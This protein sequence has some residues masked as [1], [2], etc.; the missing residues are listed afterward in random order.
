VFFSNN[1]TWDSGDTQLWESNGST[2]DYPVTVL[3][4]SG[5][6]TV[7]ATMNIPNVSTSGTYYIIAYVDP[8]TPSFPNGFFQESTRSNNIAVYPVTINTSQ[9]LPDLTN[10]ANPASSY[11]AGQT[12]VQFQVTVNRAGGPLPTSGIYVLD[13]MYFSNNSTFDSGDTQLWESNGST[14]DYPVS[15]LNS[16]GTRTVTPTITIPNVSTSGGTYYIIVY[17]DPTNFY[18]ES[19]EN[20]NITVYPVTINAAQPPDLTNSANPATSYNAGQTGVQ[21]QVTVNRSGGPLP[22]SG[23]YVLDRVF[24]S[25]NSTWDSGDTQLWE[26]NG[27]TPDYPVSVLNSSGTKTVT[28]TMNIPNVSTS[29]TYYIIAYVDPTNFYCLPCNNKCFT[30]AA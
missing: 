23:I 3:N 18:A 13:R 7:T 14:P 11:N 29:G 12:G 6:K 22:T 25:N 2:P 4:S 8:P 15:V 21:F 28:A 26:S 10:S 5:T 1:S 20:N 17:V 30:A 24:F 27:S 9:P 19:N 16:S